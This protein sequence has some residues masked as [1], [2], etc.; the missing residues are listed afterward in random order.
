[1]AN[2]KYL[3]VVLDDYTSMRVGRE[4]HGRDMLAAIVKYIHNAPSLEHLVVSKTAIKLMDLK[5]LHT[6]LL[7]LKKLDLKLYTFIQTIT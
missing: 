2:L 4:L 5:G 7:K 6:S 3:E 1:M